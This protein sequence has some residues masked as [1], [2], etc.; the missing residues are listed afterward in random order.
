MKL[1]LEE[2]RHSGV[3]LGGGVQTNHGE[4]ALRSTVRTP[5]RRRHSGVL[6]GAGGAILRR[7]HSGVLS[8]GPEGA[9]SSIVLGNI[10]E[11]CAEPNNGEVLSEAGG[12]IQDYYFTKSIV[13]RRDSRVLIGAGESIPEYR[14]EPEKAIRSIVRSRRRLSHVLSGVSNQT[15]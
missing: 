2:A 13:L 7:G 8:E 3:L 4:E 14:S 9:L 11:Y 10:Q 15:C 6:S 12:G 1:V 5:F